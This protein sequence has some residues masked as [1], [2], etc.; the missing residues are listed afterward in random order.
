MIKTRKLIIVGDSSFAEIAYEYFKYDSVYDVVA[1][2]VEKEYLKQTSLFGL[3]VVPFEEL[4][5]TYNPQHYDIFV[6]T[7]Y[8]QLNR[9]RTRLYLQ[10]KEWGYGIASYISSKAF[11]WPNAQIGEHCFIFENNVVQPFV[12]LG[13]N[14]VLWSGNHIGHH[15]VIR[16]NCFMASHVVI[17]GHCDI[18][19]NCFF[20]VNCTV[21]DQVKIENDCILGAGSILLKG[22]LPKGSVLKSIPTEIASVD[23]YRI[24]KLSNDKLNCLSN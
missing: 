17:S 18:G 4:T 7:V 19:E 15:S 6:A 9:L 21:A 2:S 1:F 23:S 22:P 12:K 3:P 13:T 8:K 14:V 20:G 16:D 5:Q 10:A 11:V 24:F